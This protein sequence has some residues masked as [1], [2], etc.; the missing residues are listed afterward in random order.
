MRNVST[1]YHHQ[2]L[3]RRSNEMGPGEGVARLG[4]TRGEFRVLVGKL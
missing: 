2:I 4:R 1:V 3:L